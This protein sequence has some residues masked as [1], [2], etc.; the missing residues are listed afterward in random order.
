MFQFLSWA[1]DSL[2]PLFLIASPITSY[3]DQIVSIHRSKSS[4]GFSIDIPL[5]MLV[6]S[7]LKVFYW[8]GAYY[9][10]MLLGQAGLMVAVQLALLKVSLD[11]KAPALVRHEPF[12]DAS[13]QH[14]LHGLLQGK[15]PYNFWRW[16]SSKPYFRFLAYLAAGLLV[17]HLL[18]PFISGSPYYIAFLGYFGLAVEAILPLPQIYKNHTARSCQGFRLSVIINW[19]VG[20]TMKM[21]YFFLSS[22]YIPWPFR[23]CAIFQTGC[24]IYLGVQFYMYRSLP[25]SSKEIQMRN[26]ANSILG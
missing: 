17:I 5:I 19:L 11:H 3:A 25:S 2:A 21:S 4:E 13:S 24:D 9:D 16:N 12:A 10:K 1:V 26:L 7:I 20:D 18:L 23:L 15:R 14:G 6:A 8:F 22:E